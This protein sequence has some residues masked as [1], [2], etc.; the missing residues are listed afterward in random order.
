LIEHF[1]LHKKIEDTEYRSYMLREISAVLAQA[2]QLNQALQVVQKIENE[3]DRS[4]ALRNIVESLA[5]AGQVDRA[6]QVAQEIEV[7]AAMA[8]AWQTE[9]ANQAFQLAL[10][11]AQKIE[12]ARGRSWALKGIAEAM[13]KAGQFDL[14][15]QIAQK[16]QEH[17][18][19]DGDSG[20]I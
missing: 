6:L 5:K 1:K 16:I 20:T 9:Q 13:A 7:A 17:R 19:S 4:E 14:A 3:Q 12:D 11:A 2:R 8:K 15:L 18:H 10:Q